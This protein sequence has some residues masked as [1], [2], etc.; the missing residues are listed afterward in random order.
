M[1][2]H[3]R[4]DETYSQV[5]KERHFVPFVKGEAERL[6]RCAIAA[7]RVLGVPD[8]SAPDPRAAARDLGI[9][10]LGDLEHFA[11][12]PEDIR[13]VMLGSREW[14]AGTLEGPGGPL[15]ITNPIHAATRLKV[16]VAEELS[17]LMMGHPPSSLDP[18]TGLRTYNK[19]V[20]DEAFSVG[21]AM[22]M[23][24]SQLYSLVDRG[25]PLETIADEFEVSVP[26]ARCRVNRT[27]LLRMHRARMKAA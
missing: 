3:A 15:I 6:E 16:T 12:L 17:H 18:T 20:E 11:A 25:Q 23:P 2:L 22:V 5:R 14:S 27:G 8:K 24:Y 7:K 19:T 13:D 1:T 10:V 4:F 26:M 9:P 21:G